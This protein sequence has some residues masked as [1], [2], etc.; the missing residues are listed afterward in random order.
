MARARGEVEEMGQRPVVSKKRLFRLSEYN[1]KC[2]CLG[3][4][5]RSM[6][7]IKGNSFS[8]KLGKTLS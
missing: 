3:S 2:Y 6:F 5:W 8:D 1:D 4:K 7:V